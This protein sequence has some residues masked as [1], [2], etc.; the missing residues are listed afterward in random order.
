[1]HRGIEEISTIIQFILN[2]ISSTTQT[3]GAVRNFQELNTLH[4]VSKDVAEVS[5]TA[6]SV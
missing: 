1:M 5:F 3:K 2:N 6:F 4:S